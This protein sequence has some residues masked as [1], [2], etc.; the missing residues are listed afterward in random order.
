MTYIFSLFIK[1]MVTRHLKF[2]VEIGCKDEI[3]IF[4]STFIKTYGICARL[5]RQCPANVM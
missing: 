3:F 1:T 4:E 2:G 5:L